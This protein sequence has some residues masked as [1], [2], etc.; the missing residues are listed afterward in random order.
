MLVF[1]AAALAVVSRSIWSQELRLPE[2]RRHLGPAIDEVFGKRSLDWATRERLRGVLFPNN[3]MSHKL[4][5]NEMWHKQQA[6]DRMAAWMTQEHLI[7]MRDSDGLHF[8]KLLDDPT[9]RIAGLMPAEFV[10]SVS[11]IM[12][13]RSILEKVGPVVEKTLDHTQLRDYL[14]GTGDV[15]DYIAVADSF[16]PAFRTEMVTFTQPTT[17]LR[18]YGGESKAIGRYF[19]CCLWS[20]VPA[21]HGFKLQWSDASGLATPP[22]NLRSDLAAVT[23]PAGTTAIIGIVADNFAD[24]F[25]HVERGGNTQIYIPVIKTFPF[26]RYLVAKDASSPWEIMVQL[27]DRILRFRRPL[28]DLSEF[29]VK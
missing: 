12:R 25:G 4:P 26:H 29:S 3:Q 21:G 13:R 7:M 19:F 22:G 6:R 20:P 16:D 2:V 17:L 14:Q 18:L 10:A 15:T 8:Q 27:D 5:N 23:I 28:F 1:F 11:S 24:Q 9:F